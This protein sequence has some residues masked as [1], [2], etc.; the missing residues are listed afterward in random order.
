MAAI[1]PESCG[2]IAKSSA[3]T[4]HCAGMGRIHVVAMAIVVS[5]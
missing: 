4:N 3:G 2:I 1:F 5:T